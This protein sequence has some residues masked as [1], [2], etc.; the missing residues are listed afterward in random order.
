M[1]A[2]KV[3]SRENIDSW[4]EDSPKLWQFR[5]ALEAMQGISDEALGDER[6]YQW[7]AGVHG[8]FGGSPFCHHGDDHFLTWHRPYLLDY[9]LKLR[10]R[11]AEFAGEAAADEWRLPYWAWDAEDVAGLPASFEAETY[12]DEGTERPNPL[13]SM[14]YGLPIPPGIEPS[15]FTFRQP[16]PLAQLQALRARVEF[17]F[18][19][20]AFHDFSTAI[21]DPHNRVH[22]WTG[23]FMATYRSAFDP[24]FWVHHANIDRM[25]WQWQQGDGHMSSIPQFVRDLPCQ[26]FKF[27]D[28]RASAFFDTRA[29]GYTYSAER[30]LV[31]RRDALGARLTDEETAPLIFDFGPIREDFA[32]VRINVHGVRHPELT[33]ELRFFANREAPAD[34]DTPEVVGEG[35]LGSY[36]VLGH[37]PCPGAPG[38]CDP[39]AP[40]DDL[41]P[42]HH[43]APFD[44]FIDVTDN[45]AALQRSG[46][47]ALVGELVVTDHTGEQLTAAALRFDNVSLTYR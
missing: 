12:D 28:I 2:T 33:V 32:R 7:C 35:Y 6:G 31:L 38:H 26:P 13:F 47:D 5:K 23:G 34:A 21:E 42:P 39:D 46:A 9:E 27:R 17:A 44:L 40:A 19:Q 37:G 11:I 3:V 1:A 20:T 18:T 25:F 43:L 24:L 16:G 8:G 29:L 14:P 4:A 41:R 30:H 10:A 36:M 45:V 15:G 22:G